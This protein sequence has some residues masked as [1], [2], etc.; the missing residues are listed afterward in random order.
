MEIDREE[1]SQLP[2]GTKIAIV[3]TVATIVNS[4]LMTVDANA[5]YLWPLTATVIGSAAFFMVTSDPFYTKL[6][7]NG[8]V[9]EQRPTVEA[10]VYVLR[11][12]PL[13]RSVLQKIEHHR[14]LFDSALPQNRE[15]RIDAAYDEVVAVFRERGIDLTA[16]Q[17]DRLRTAIE[18]EW[19]R[20]READ[21]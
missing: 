15:S 4:Y 7:N 20:V 14:A 5:I 17:K 6:K 11:R 19:N 21:D 16:T 8:V 1:I 9:P 3:G 12:R 13:R 2:V 10:V 18:D